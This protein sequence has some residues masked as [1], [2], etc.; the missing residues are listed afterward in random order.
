MTEDAKRG[1]AKRFD[2][3]KP[4]L[5]DL[6]T[7]ALLDVARVFSHGSK[8]YGRHNWRKGLLY[9]RLTA[10]ALRHIFAW[11]A[12]DN[13]DAESGLSHLSHAA[14]NLLILLEQTK[15]PHFSPH[16]DD[17]HPYSD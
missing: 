8:K 6:P 13:Y 11:L 7:E 17:R 2:A 16:L 10:A 1:G 3:D 4:P 15:N 5:A 14:W 12:G 9:S